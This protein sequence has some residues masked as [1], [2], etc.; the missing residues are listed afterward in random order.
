MHKSHALLFAGCITLEKV[1][2]KP[3]AVRGV[4]L[5]Q[6]TSPSRLTL[7]KAETLRLERVRGWTFILRA[8]KPRLNL[9]GD[10]EGLPYIVAL[11]Q[12]VLLAHVLLTRRHE[13]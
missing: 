11:L 5:R 7:F 6:C 3:F 8:S 10:S 12:A 1:S 2:W 4:T 13:A 9:L